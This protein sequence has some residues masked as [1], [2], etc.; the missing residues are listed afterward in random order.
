MHTGVTLDVSNGDVARSARDLHFAANILCGNCAAG[1]GELRVTI[2]LFN[3]N[4]SGSRADF[5]R[6]TQVA[7]VYRAG[8]NVGVHLGVVGNLNLVSDGDIAHTGK[9]FANANRVASLLYRGIRHNVVQTLLRILKSETGGAYFGVNRYCSGCSRGDIH[10]ARGIAELQ[11][12]WARYGVG[13]REASVDGWAGV[14]ACKRKSGG[15]EQQGT[16]EIRL[17]RHSSSK[18]TRNKPW[19]VPPVATQKQSVMFPKLFWA[20]TARDGPALR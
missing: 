15:E 18:E 7:D 8:G 6:A 19:G 10:V 4:T 12:G 16:A 20:M 2:D 17:A 3:V 5:Y 1:G 14:T 13:A 11:T 9:I